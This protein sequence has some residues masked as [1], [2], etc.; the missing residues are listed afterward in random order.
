MAE[1]F[2]IVIH[3]VGS[4]FRIPAVVVQLEGA[5]AGRRGSGGVRHLLQPRR[6]VYHV[7]LARGMD[8]VAAPIRRA[9]GLQ[10]NDLLHIFRQAT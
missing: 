7:I 2:F 6:D 9:P 1:I 8:A 4:S 5:V 3:T 10:Q